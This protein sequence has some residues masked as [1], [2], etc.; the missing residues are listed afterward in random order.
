MKCTFNAMRGTR[1][2]RDFKPQEL[3][4]ERKEGSKGEVYF[5]CDEGDEKSTG[6]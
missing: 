1:S 4:G 2:P 5:Q 3:S 6:L